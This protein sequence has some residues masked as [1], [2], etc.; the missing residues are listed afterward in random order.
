MVEGQHEEGQG[1]GSGKGCSGLLSYRLKG[2]AG[3]GWG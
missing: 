3:L 1:A 2:G